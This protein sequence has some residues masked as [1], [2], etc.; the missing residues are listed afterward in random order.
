MFWIYFCKVLSVSR[1]VTVPDCELLH[2]TPGLT[3]PSH[4]MMIYDDDYGDDDDDDGDDDDGDD[5]YGDDDDDDGD[6]DGPL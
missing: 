5:D 2:F 1:C 6:D 4:P 3:T